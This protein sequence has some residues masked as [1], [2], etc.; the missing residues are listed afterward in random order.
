MGEEQHFGKT[1]SR[2]QKAEMF[3]VGDLLAIGVMLLVLALCLC[4]CAG[5]VRPA[6]VTRAAA[7]WDGT[8]QNSGFIC[9]TNGGGIIT[10][11]AKRRYDSLRATYGAQESPPVLAAAGI[12]PGPGLATWF[13]DDEHL[14]LF[15]K[16][17]R[18]KREGRK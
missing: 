5:T 18:W 6:P 4:G 1:E 10:G 7:S 13:I 17:T 9:F 3:A 12:S 8:N 11:E 15:A 2:K 16:W 14:A